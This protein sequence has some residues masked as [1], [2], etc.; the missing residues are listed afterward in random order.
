MLTA[1]PAPSFSFP[2]LHATRYV[3]RQIVGNAAGEFWFVDPGDRGGTVRAKAS[4]GLA[5][6]ANAGKRV[7]AIASE[8]H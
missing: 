1:P 7:G 3:S 5:F 4:Y 6:R 2:V 8:G